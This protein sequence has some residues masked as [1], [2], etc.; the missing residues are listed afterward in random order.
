[1]LLQGV[2]CLLLLLP[3]LMQHAPHHL[4]Y[5]MP[6]ATCHMPQ[7]IPNCNGK[8]GTNPSAEGVD[9]FLSLFLTFSLANTQKSYA[10]NMHIHTH[11]HTPGWVCGAEKEA[12]EGW[13]A[14]VLMC[15]LRERFQLINLRAREHLFC[16]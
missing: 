1:M 14:Y 13:G 10:S 5:S 9:S 11:T 6:H 8:Q 7:A 3:F 4:T 2:L 12:G 16:Y 15:A